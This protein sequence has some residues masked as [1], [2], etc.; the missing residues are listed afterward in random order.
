MN[1][2]YLLS[3]LIAATYSFNVQAASTAS[4]RWF[5]IELLIFKRNVDTQKIDEQ[6]D[7]N[8]IYLKKRK[9]LEVLKAKE[10]TNCSTK[11]S[12]LHKQP[13]VN[14]TNNDIVDAGHGLKLLDRSHLQ[15][16]EQRR[17]LEQHRLFKP[18]IHAAWRMPVKS[19]R[20]ALPLHLFAGKNYALAS[21]QSQLAG[22]DL[23]E[24]D[25]DLLIYVERYLHVDSQLIVRTEIEKEISIV[26][27]LASARQ[28]ANRDSS[29]AAE[30]MTQES[31]RN[32]NVKIENVITETLF[33][34]KRRLRSEEIHYLDHPLFGMI[35]QIRKIPTNELATLEK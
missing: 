21:S 2:R 22:Q 30:V 35:I 17:K 26:S 34:Q 12:C 19:Q 5:D 6:L 14:I 1:R 11:L 24:I 4:D 20:N 7:Q 9:R 18:L 33:D 10:V 31:I 25:G 32:N 3:L 23:F 27:S 28:K 29:N 15:L 8:N 13:P 16:T